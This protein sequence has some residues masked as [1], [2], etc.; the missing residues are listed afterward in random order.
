MSKKRL[1]EDSHVSEGEMVRSQPPSPPE[2]IEMPDYVMPHWWAVVR[3]R[4]YTAW[5]PTDLE[6]A[7][8]L[9]HCLA[10][11]ERLRREIRA[12]GD[13]LENNRGTPVQN[14]KH[15]LLE[16]IS[17]R[18]VALSKLIHVHAEAT[19]GKSR[20][21][22]QRNEKQKEMSQAMDQHSDDGLIAPPTQ[23]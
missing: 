9:A 22:R 10:D 12:E 19:A 20:D 11:S 2:H 4:E 6:H 8:N 15:A 17:R 18:A 14:P 3:A 5:T 21:D 16:Q 1:R 7:A 13:V 23:H